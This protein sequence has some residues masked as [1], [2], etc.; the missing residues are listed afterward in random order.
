VAVIASK[1]QR[2]VDVHGG[3]KRNGGEIRDYLKEN[4]AGIY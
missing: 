3:R 2:L 4:A 1:E